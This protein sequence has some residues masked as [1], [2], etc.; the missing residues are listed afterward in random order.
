VRFVESAL[1]FAQ[2][3]HNGQK[4]RSGEAYIEH[5]IA[6]ASQL[7]VMRLDATTLAAALLH[8]VIED[9]G[10]TQAELQQKFG[11]EVARLVDGVTK[12][13]K[14]DLISSPDQQAPES[15][16]TPEAARTAS[17]RKMLV[18]MAEDIR[19]V[20]IK[21]SDRLHNMQTLSHMPPDRQQRIARE[22]LDIY[23]PLAHRLGMADIKWK[24]EDAAFRYLMPREYQTVSRLINRKRAE[25][26]EYA[27]KVVGVLDAALKA[28]G[29]NAQVFGRP[30]HLYSTWNKMNRYQAMGREFNEI[31]DLTGIRVIV[32]TVANCYAALGVVHGLW[33]PVQGQF[34]DYVATPKDN[35]YQSLHTSVIAEGGSAVEIQIRTKEMNRI[36]EDG[37]AAHWAYKEGDDSADDRFEQKM[38]WL[39]QLLDWQREVS[40]DDE[41]L[42]SVKTDILRDQVFVNT[43]RGDVI[44]LPAGAT[45][46]DFAY[47][48]HTELGHNCVGAV[49]NG[50]LVTLSTPLKNGD[51]VEIK[52][53]RAPRGPS[54]DWLNEDLGYLQTASAQ[55]KV[56]AW[57]RRQERSANVQRGLDQ[58]RR[59]LRRLNVSE[60]DEVIATRLGFKAVDELAEAV[61]SGEMTTTQIVER[62]A[63]PRQPVPPAGPRP[64]PV[65]T[66]HGANGES[67]IVVMGVGNMLTRLALCCAPVYGDEIAGY[68]TRGRGVTVHRRNCPTFVAA[69]DAD[70]IVQAGWG[71]SDQSHPVR[72]VLE[73]Y[74]R[75]GLLRDI[76]NV[77]SGE[78][79]NIHSMSSN[80]DPQSGVSTVSLTVYTTGVEQLSRLFSK[81]EAIPGV[82]NV[83]RS[84]V[85]AIAPES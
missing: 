38:S 51:T 61:G 28:A 53:S 76:T 46:L 13:K 69:Q 62:L 52:K 27:Q 71:H 14:L 32:D 84:A 40:G 47:R 58:L 21:L 59:D 67:G 31:Y 33:K 85:P 63:V 10:I 18:A 48:I 39:K 19:V 5:P 11:A 34:D 26:E 25:R 73:S 30:K 12:L 65:R 1:D 41:Y 81:L 2:R 22:T 79:I 82:R 49:V 16:T 36:A 50:K 56:R 17:L 29:V 60:P 6:T 24:L 7:A 55:G 4:R 78:T 74:D 75:V 64:R 43:P 72:L 20:L 80:E 9:C 77:V 44:D 35:F 83:Q 57:F 66:A 3:A 23:A 37:I 70:R 42:H 45:P 15:P 8:D 54:L 68:I